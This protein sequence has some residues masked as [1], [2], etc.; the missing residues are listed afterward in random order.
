[1]PITHANAPL[2]GRGVGILLGGVNIDTP[3]EKQLQAQV[4]ACR[5]GMSE[6]LASLILSLLRG[7]PH[8]G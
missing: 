5:L 2:M 6:P 3:T 7:E 8:H 1:M 4:L